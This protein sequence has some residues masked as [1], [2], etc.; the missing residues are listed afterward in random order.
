MFW[1][2]P[3]LDSDAVFGVKDSLVREV[4]AVD[5]AE[6]AAVYGVAAP[7]RLSSSTWCSLTWRSRASQ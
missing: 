3:L 2:E 1:P 6:L 5:D 7:F 4:R